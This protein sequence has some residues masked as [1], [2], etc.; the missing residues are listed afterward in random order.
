MILDVRLLTLWYVTMILLFY[1]LVPFL[2]YNYDVK[3]IIL[4]STIIFVFLT[5]LY[6]KTSFINVRLLYYFPIFIFGLIVSRKN[7]LQSMFANY[8]VLAIS[9]VFL[10]MVF[11]LFYLNESFHWFINIL[12]IAFGIFASLPVIWALGKL[13]VNIFNKKIIQVVS[14][15]SFCMYLTHRIILLGV[16]YYKPTSPVLSYLYLL[17]VWLPLIVLISYFVQRYYDL[18][19]KKILPSKVSA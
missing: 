15:S 13:C 5:F 18:G 1:I 11:S 16:N 14:Y 6:W 4:L 8:K 12:V 9:V 10:A 17:C 7:K 19:I 3:K 2:L